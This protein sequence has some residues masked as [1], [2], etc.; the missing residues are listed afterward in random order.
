MPR[1]SKTV[2]YKASYQ[3][4]MRVLMHLMDIKTICQLQYKMWATRIQHFIS[5]GFNSN[6]TTML[7][8]ALSPQIN[9]DNV[10]LSADHKFTKTCGATARADY[11]NYNNKEKEQKHYLKLMS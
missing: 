11:S 1:Q 4:P 9:P 5:V 8:M 10:A 6:N 2:S 7:N 3:V